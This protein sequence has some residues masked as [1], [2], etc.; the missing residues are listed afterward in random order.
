[1]AFVFDESSITIKTDFPHQVEKRTNLRISMADGCQLAADIWLPEDAEINPV[2]AILEYI[3]YRKNDLTAP[4]DSIRHPYF[5]GHGYACLRV[6]LRGCGDSDGVLYDE[7]L[8]QELDDGVAVLHWIAD[9]PWCDG[10]VGIIGKSWG[11]FNGLQIAALQPPMLK[12]VISLC[13]TDDRY[14][15]DVHYMGGSL[16]ASDMLWWASIMLAYNAL[17]PDPAMV[18]KRWRKMWLHRLEETPPFIE[19]WLEHS[20]R[21][22]YWQHGSV[23][24]NYTNI[25]CPVYAVGGWADG[26]TNAVFRLLA[27]LP[28]PRKGLIGPWVHEY[29]EVATPAPGIGF[30]QECLRWWD[31]WLKGI[32]TGVMNEPM[33]HAWLQESAAPQSN[34]TSR[35][36]RWIAEQSWPTRQKQHQYFL[37]AAEQL[38]PTE[39]TP[40]QERIAQ[41]SGSQLH[42]FYCGV[43]CPF[44]EEGDMATDQQIEDIRSTCF[45][46]PPM[47]QQTDY[48]GFPTIELVFSV[49]QP[50]AQVAVRLCDIPPSDAKQGSESRLVSWGML[51]LTHAAEADASHAAPKLLVP[52][53]IYKVTVQLNAIGHTLPAGHRWRVALSTTYWPHMWP[54]P[55]PVM[56]TLY[57]GCRLALPERRAQLTDEKL[58]PFGPPE[59]APKMRI[60]TLRPASRQRSV[61]H[62]LVAESATLFN[63]SDGGAFR[64]RPTDAPFTDIEFGTI[65]ED[66]YTITE[67]DPLSAKVTCRRV[68]LLGRN[69]W[70]V[71]IQTESRMWCDAEKFH[72]FNSVHCFEGEDEAEVEI[73]ARESDFSTQRR[74]L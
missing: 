20:R 45:T 28:G 5:A 49:D 74:F 10:N 33:L 60:D 6:D 47:K 18:G 31:Q 56:L 24:E 62:D 2:P 4:R 55:T 30:L 38:S 43:W 29:P 9:Q 68:I 73:F 66:R 67:G 17:P 23:C 37:A 14:A 21:D 63:R 44:G 53:R 46:S 12:A 35:P 61:T 59:I 11:G 52:D 72:V 57:S 22:A 65:D 26:Y 48:L 71:R 7:Y 1:M 19:K 32:D 15:D 16:L 8:Q 41:L 42:G 51:N 13:S 39:S 40:N 3:P 69:G 70:R 36:G 54:S 50:M 64:L 25:K 27:N 58:A 34:Y